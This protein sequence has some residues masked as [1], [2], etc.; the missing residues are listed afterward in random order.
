MKEA[1]K[2]LELQPT[3]CT[4][5]GTK[6][7]RTRRPANQDKIN[8]TVVALENNVHGHPSASLLWQRKLEEMEKQEIE[9]K[10]KLGM[11]VIPSK[12]RNVLVKKC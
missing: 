1:P 5:I 3:E 10:I 12:S 2:L 11:L 4:T 6:R 9:E 8:R 7:P